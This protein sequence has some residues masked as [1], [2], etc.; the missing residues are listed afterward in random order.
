[1]RFTECSEG[2][3]KLL[4]SVCSDTLHATKGAE[5]VI[6]EV[7]KSIQTLVLES[8]QK[9]KFGKTVHSNCDVLARSLVHVDNQ[10]Q[11]PNQPG[12]GW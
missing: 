12:A 2:A 9:H 8:A 4:A 5:D 11:G 7:S 1:M 3:S 6:Q 10:V